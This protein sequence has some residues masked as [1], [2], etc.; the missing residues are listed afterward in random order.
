MGAGTAVGIVLVGVAGIVSVDAVV[1]TGVG[2][3]PV[4]EGRFVVGSIATAGT[5]GDVGVGI[6]GVGIGVGIAGVDMV[7]GE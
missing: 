5:A 4:V 3:G 2:S 7:V 6:V 1:G